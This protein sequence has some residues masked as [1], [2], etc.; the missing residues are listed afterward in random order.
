V[1]EVK[2]TA[3]KGFG[4]QTSG[5]FVQNGVQF[6]ISLVFAR[7]LL[8][9]EYGVAMVAFTIAE[10][11]SLL[12]VAGLAQACIASP[13]SDDEVRDTAFW[14]ALGSGL[15]YAAVL[16]FGA[17]LFASVLGASG[18]APLLRALSVVQ[19]VDSFRVVPFS[20]LMRDLRYRDNAICEAVPFVVGCL[21]AFALAAIVPPQQRIWALM[22]MPLTRIVVQSLLFNWFQPGMP[23]RWLDKEVARELS[24]SGYTILGSNL[25]SSLLELIPTL[26]VQQRAGEVAAGAFRIGNNLMVPAARIGHTANYTLFPILAKF[27]DDLERLQR[28]ILRS[29]RTIGA[30]AMGILGW[31]WVAAPDLVPLLFGKA[32]LNAVPAAQWLAVASALRLYTYIGTNALLATGRERPSLVVWTGSLAV[33]VVA[34]YTIPMTG[35]DPTAGAIALT[36][37]TGAGFLLSVGALSRAL[38]LHPVDVSVALAPALLSG[39]TGIAVGYGFGALVGADLQWLHLLAVS[40]GFAV[41]FLPVCGVLLGGRP[42]SLLTPSGIKQLIQRN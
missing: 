18:L 15:L 9:E 40:V 32:W 28:S 5:V 38:K 1:S 41:G 12:R 3:I 4:W 39:S 24:I 7:L 20:L 37:A 2:R 19:I 25:P 36:M 17:D 31:A 33:G 26:A 22:A 8:R 13:R 34:L 29:M 23:R 11:A 21:L 35:A 27:R 14:L 6:L 16:F 10:L 30:L 42:H